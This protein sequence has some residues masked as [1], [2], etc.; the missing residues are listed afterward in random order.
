MEL[1]LF[2]LLMIK[3]LSPRDPGVG[4]ETNYV[5][6]VEAILQA[7]SSSKTVTTALWSAWAWPRA[8]KAL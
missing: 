4:L 1:R 3:L 2:P 6:S 7:A 5:F 8:L